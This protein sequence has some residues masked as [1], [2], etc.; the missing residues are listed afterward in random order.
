MKLLEPIKT[1][2]VAALISLVLYVGGDAEVTKPADQKLPKAA[3]DLVKAAEQN[4]A[5][6]EA[7]ISHL[8]LTLE[9]AKANLEKR[10]ELF[11]KGIVSKLEITAGEE[12]VKKAQADLDK[13]RS[14]IVETD[15]LIAEAREVPKIVAPKWT[16]APAV[17]RSSGAGGWLLSRSA[18]VR[19]FFSS[20][21]GRELPISAFG[22]TS[23]HNRLGF[24]HHNSLDVAIHPDSSEGKALISY[25]RSTGIPFLAF[26]SAVSG[27]A[28]G[29]HIHIGHPS[30]RL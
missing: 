9:T 7:L 23:T 6:I 16:T 25:L 27:V 18:Q 22:Q 28:T 17:I 29:A 13:A 5:S 20:R 15:Q 11:E 12:A 24:A 2:S 4:K 30:N 21:F 19:D 10:R 8:S 14:Q 1:L 3:S 26:R